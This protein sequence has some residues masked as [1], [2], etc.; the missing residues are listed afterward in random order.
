MVDRDWMEQI[1]QQQHI[2]RLPFGL[3]WTIAIT[4]VLIALAAAGLPA[5]VEAFDRLRLAD[6]RSAFLTT[7][8]PNGFNLGSTQTLENADL[9]LMAGGSEGALLM[10]AR[11]YDDLLIVDGKRQRVWADGRQILGPVREGP[12]PGW[13]HVFAVAR[14]ITTDAGTITD[15]ADRTGLTR[16]Q[17]G[18][19]LARLGEHVHHTRL[20]WEAR[21]MFD[22]IDWAIAAYPGPGGVRTRWKRADSID[23]QADDLI[24]AGGM[25]SDLWAAHQ[26]WPRVPPHRLVA[27]FAEH[28]D[29]P[30]LGFEPAGMD[31]ASV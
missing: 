27:Y 13:Q 10:L 9:I 30:A 6:G 15:I 25:M 31:E 3:S 21:N 12:T 20:G 19:A 14:T 17:V 28:P 29:M 24:A 18:D 4:D 11:R 1:R 2:L 5:T 22:L 26:S 16:G 7:P 23:A 8:N